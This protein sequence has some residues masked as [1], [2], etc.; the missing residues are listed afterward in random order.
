[1]LH[2]API[3][4]LRLPHRTCARRDEHEAR[5]GGF[6]QQGRRE[7]GKHVCPAH[8][9]VPRG[10]ERLADRHLTVADLAVE[11]RAGVVDQGVEPAMPGSENC[12]SG[13]ERFIRGHVNLDGA[14]GGVGVSNLRLKLLDCILTL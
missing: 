2:A 14:E 10:V 11:A 3:L 8:V 1:M 6:Q 13:L 9:G 12:D 7:V 4:R 5:V